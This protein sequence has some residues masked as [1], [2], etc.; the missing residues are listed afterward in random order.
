VVTDATD[1]GGWR[2]PGA[3][4]DRDPRKIEH[5]ARVIS[6]APQ[7]L[8]IAQELVELIS[9]SADQAPEPVL[10]LAQRAGAIQRYLSEMPASSVAADDAIAAE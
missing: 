9:L 8:A 6:C 1:W 2:T 5:Q 7:L 3:E 4:Y 10:A